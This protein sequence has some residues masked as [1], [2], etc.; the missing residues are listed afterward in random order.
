MRPGARAA[1]AIEVLREIEERHRPAAD[2]LKDWGRA[3]RF[4]GSGDRAAIGNLVYD[5]LRRKASF[6]HAAGDGSPAALV[7]AALRIGRGMTEDEIAALADEPHGAP[8]LRRPARAES[9]LEPN[10]PAWVAGDFPD[11]LSA[12]FERTFGSDAALEG[13]ALARRA[14]I[15]LRVNTLKTDAARVLKALDKFGARSGR[16]SPWC[17][18]IPAP[19][20]DAR[21]PDIEAEPA[22]GKGWY[23]VQ[24]EGSQVAALL[25]GA[26]PGMQV[27]DLCA[28]A[29]GKT[30]ALAAS[31]G[32]KGQIFAHD[33]DRHRLRPIFE[34]LKRAGARNVQ[35]VPADEPARLE[36]LAGHMDAVLVDA[37]CSGSGSWRRKPDAKWRLTPRALEARIEEQRA[38]LRQAASMVKP[39]GRLAYVTCSVLPEENTDQVTAFHADHPRFRVEQVSEVWA[40]ALGT[41]QPCS[42]GPP[43]GTLLLTPRRHDTD[44][45]FVALLRREA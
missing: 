10:C 13:A 31:M 44:G 5:V 37:P 42:A 23:E 19:E 32:N 36:A 2:A 45:F 39:G 11:W 1:A 17:V 8:E 35:V 21:A 40:Q 26:R 20:G 34:R 22:H 41:P 7:R 38:L 33:A 18:R 29:G 14:P 4:A 30:L 9:P 15:D 24:D 43:D 3:H 12:S 27:L 16:W 6:S 28:G 25:V